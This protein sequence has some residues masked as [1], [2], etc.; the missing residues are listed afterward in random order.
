[1]LKT[2]VYTVMVVLPLFAAALFYLPSGGW[3][4]FLVPLMLVG[5]WEWGVLAGW[6]VAGRAAY[7]CAT[8]LGGAVL[9][10]FGG[11]GV[12]GV[13]VRWLYPV[14]LG[15]SVFFWLVV[16]PLW[17]A[18]GWRVRAPL[19][20]ALTGAV[21]I[22][23]LWVALIQLQARPLQLLVLMAVVWISDSTAYLCGRLWGRRKLAVTIS[24]GK[25]WEGVFGA[26]VGVAL[27]YALVSASGIVE[28][29]LLQGVGGFAVFMALAV[30]GIEGDLFES[31]IKRTAGMKDSGG[32]FPG[33]GGVLDRVDALTS[34]MP[35]AAL[36]LGG[37]T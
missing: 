2:R 37:V 26:L 11:G 21:L 14:L 32:F 28:Y 35:A 9:W 24:P 25:T 31:W 7:V 1:M 19:V 4:L 15:A 20:M 3:A 30:L 12:A 36:L 34:S 18:K 22:L 27:Y 13:D 8:A 5:A 6:G 23:P 17:L 16:T 33:H 29:G 10:Y